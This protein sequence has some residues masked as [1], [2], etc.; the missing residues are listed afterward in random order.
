VRLESSVTSI[1]WIPLNAIEGIVKMP[2]EMG[3]AHYDLPPPDE[4]TDL[5][6]LI[7]SSAIRFANELRAW[8]E[9]ED[10]RIT[11]HGYSG[12]GHMGNTRMRVGGINLTFYGI[13]FPDLRAEPSVRMV[14]A[15]VDH[16][17]G[18]AIFTNGRRRTRRGAG[19]P[20]RPPAVWV[21]RTK[22]SPTSGSARRSGNAIP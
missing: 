8:I 14:S 13:A 5:E 1:S 12:R 21:K 19:M 16:T 10:G 22:S 9:V 18:P 17:T 11:G 7:S 3:V 20:G 15:R 4:L 2:F 6:E